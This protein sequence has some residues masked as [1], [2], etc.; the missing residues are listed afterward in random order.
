[1]GDIEL[2]YTIIKIRQ[3]AIDFPEYR[4]IF[5][6]LINDA[7]D[8]QFVINSLKVYDE[9]TERELNKSRELLKLIS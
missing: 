4:P 8:K 2:I 3:K 1:M 5:L 6:D 7:E 9:R